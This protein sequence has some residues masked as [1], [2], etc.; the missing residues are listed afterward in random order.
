MLLI[1]AAME[2]ELQV[3]LSLCQNHKRIRS[4]SVSI[5]QGTR[6]GQRI[7]FLKTGVG[8]RKAA[9]SLE[10]ALEAIPFSEVLVIGYCGAL[11]PG[12]TLGKLV[13]VERAF[14]C[15]LDEGVAS[16]EN[17]RMD[18]T[19]KLA[20]GEALLRAARSVGL[21]AC[22]GDSLTSAHVV[23]DPEHKRLLFD[24]FHAVIVD[25]E[26]AAFARVAAFK[27]VPLSCIRAVSD[28]S[29]DAFLAP[30]SYDPSA[31]LTARAARI[32]RKGNP[33]KAYREWR[34]HASV[35]RSTLGRFLAH[36]L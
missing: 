3:A 6:N 25:M 30:F 11:E 17:M 29:Q 31:T 27:A 36:Y 10:R 33:A 12:L 21:D 4:Q 26:T 34:R 7:S 35:A 24:R 2:E 14:A 32:I 23:G 22:L 16:L 18:D 9:K 13:V 19:F 28:E 20:N 1:A 8:P 5:R 15:S